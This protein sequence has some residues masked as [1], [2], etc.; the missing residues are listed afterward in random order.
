MEPAASTPDLARLLCVLAGAFGCSEGCHGGAYELSGRTPT[1]GVA[2]S[3]NGT[4]DGA[5]PSRNHQMLGNN[6][7]RSTPKRMPLCAH[8]GSQRP[9]LD[10]DGTQK[11]GNRHLHL[12]WA[13]FNS[14]I[15]G[16]VNKLK[17]F[18]I[19][20]NLV[21]LLACLL[22]NVGIHSAVELEG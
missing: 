4:V 14:A 2:I 5:P 21:K 22:S 20:H 15:T 7:S 11:C 6:L 19:D 18:A 10:A 9:S 8:P 3:V 17:P 16:F 13:F 12:E 1:G